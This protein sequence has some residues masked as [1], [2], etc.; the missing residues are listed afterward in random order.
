MKFT[1]EREAFLKPLQAVQGVVERR[2]T[3]PI[4]SNLLVSATGDAL[5]LT[6]T[7]MEVEL[8]ARAPVPDAGEGEV[9]VPARKLIDIC[10]SLPAG[11]TVDFALDGE[12]VIVKSGRSRFTLSTLPAA[13][14][15]TTD[16]LADEV[17]FSI[18]Q[19]ELKKLIELT[20]F[21]MAHQD[22]RY[23]LNGLL[24][25]LSADGIKAV[26][27][28]GHRLAVSHVE[29]QTTVTEPRSLIV[30]RKG[31]VELSRLLDGGEDAESVEEAVDTT[32]WLATLRD[33]GPT[34]GF[35][36]DSKPIS[37]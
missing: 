18:P 4:L 2:Q 8:G 3:L 19:G 12:R 26:A 16:D 9:T 29:V 27:T 24:L 35:F 7:D 15:P 30:P 6:A 10:R 11:A 37:W 17:S 33:D 23:Y 5:S 13:D 34:G 28:D 21:A 1:I 14:F 31:I 22:V 32:I 20:Q 25:E 36:R